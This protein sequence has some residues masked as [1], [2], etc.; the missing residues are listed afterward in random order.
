MYISGMQ[1]VR[2]CIDLL[3]RPGSST[4]AETK[5]PATS[6]LHRY[7][8]ESLKKTLRKRFLYVFCKSCPSM[9]CYRRF[10]SCPPRLCWPTWLP[11]LHC[12]MVLRA[13]N[14]LLRGHTTLLWSLLKVGVVFTWNQVKIICATK[15]FQ[16]P[17]LVPSYMNRSASLFSYVFSEHNNLL[18]FRSEESRTPAA[19]WDVLW[20]SEDQLQRGSQRHPGAS[21]A[22]ADKPASLHRGSGEDESRSL[23]FFLISLEHK[24]KHHKLIHHISLKNMMKLWVMGVCHWLMLLVLWQDLL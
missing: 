6:A 17:C 3:C 12:T 15:T 20:H 11:C 16:F 13:S 14:T 10:F 23:C 21:R 2:R 4:S 22:E 9:S 5:Q 8:W 18:C 7:D 19:Q 1:P 24:H